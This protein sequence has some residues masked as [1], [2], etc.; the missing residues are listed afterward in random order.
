MSAFDFGLQFL[1]AD[2]MTY[3]GKRRDASFWIENASVR[4]NEAEA[5]FHTVARLTLL[6]K[7]QLQPDV[8]STA[9][10]VELDQRRSKDRAF[11][12]LARLLNVLDRN[13]PHRI[14]HR[15][16]LS[17]LARTSSKGRA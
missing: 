2:R 6:S 12:A 7:S 17:C 4:W 10:K 15:L 13:R 3:W 9:C 8:R 14:D 11:D 1:D 5:P 16:T